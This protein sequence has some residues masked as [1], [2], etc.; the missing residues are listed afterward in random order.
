MSRKLTLGLISKEGRQ[1]L[2]QAKERLFNL[3]EITQC[4]ICKEKKQLIEF[5]ED[6][7]GKLGYSN[8]CLVCSKKMEH[9]HTLCRCEKCGELKE[10]HKFYVVRR[11]GYYKYCIDCTKQI[12]NSKADTGY[13]K[14][15][16]VCKEIKP[17]STKY[18]DVSVTSIDSLQRKCK[19]CCNK[20][21][22]ESS[23]K[24]NS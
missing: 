20:A 6:R 9:S 5:A 17:A 7:N 21:K 14:Q 8:I 1:N 10:H 22:R 23:L 11:Q 16:P 13:K 19:L 4:I 3:L 15:C 24:K 18:F 2:K 12:I